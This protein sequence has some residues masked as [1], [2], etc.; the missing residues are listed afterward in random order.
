MPTVTIDGAILNTVTVTGQYFDG[1]T[2]AYAGGSVSFQM[3]DQVY[4]L[5]AGV[6]V[7]SSVVTAQLNASG[8][9]SVNLLAMDNAALSQNWYWQ[10]TGTIQGVALPVKRL[11]VMFAWGPTQTIAQLLAIASAGVVLC[12]IPSSAIL[13]LF[14]W[15]AKPV[16]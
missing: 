13:L 9:F 6:C 5:V 14:R 8:S 10:Y 4:A 3:T 7:L 15:V 12:L 11:T 2:G 1:N 16:R